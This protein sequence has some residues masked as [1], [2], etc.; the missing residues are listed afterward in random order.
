MRARRDHQAGPGHHG[1][2]RARWRSAAAVA[3]AAA[4]S[5]AAGAV[6]ASAVDCYRVTA[7]IP[8]GSGPFGVAVDPAAHTAYVTNSNEATVSVIDTATRAV[9]ATIPVGP[10]PEGVA[11]DPAAA[12]VYVTSYGDN[13]VSVI[14]AAANSVTATVRVG[15]NPWGVAVDPAAGTAYVTNFGQGTV[16]VI[17]STP[18]PGPIVS[19]YHTRTS[20][21]IQPG[22]SPAVN[23]TL[24][25]LEPCN[26]S[27]VQDWTVGPDGTIRSAAAG[28]CLDTYRERKQNKTPVDLSACNGRPGQQWKRAAGTLVNTVSGKCLDDPRFTTPGARLQ[29]YTCKKGANQKWELPA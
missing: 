3:A 2:A 24:A 1:G 25:V 27:R 21:C 16:S 17:N 8:V 18:M 6:P 22:A 7:T 23:G 26:H 4:L 20:A 12:T 15:S 19:G 14:D 5:L 9:T 28:L 11:V 10:S 13:K 29:I